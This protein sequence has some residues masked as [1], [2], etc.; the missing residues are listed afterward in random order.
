MTPPSP[1]SSRLTTTVHSRDAAGKMYVY[2]V[3]SRRAGGVSIGINL[4]PNHACNWRCIYCQVPGLTLGSGPPTD[5]PRLRDEL[6]QML[7]EILHG[8]FLE[9]RV[10]AEAR[11]L[12]DVA[13]SGD[14]EPTTSPSFEEAVQTVGEVLGEH[15]LVGA[16]DVVLITNGSQLQRPSVQAGVSALARLGGTVW[17]KLD[18]GNRDGFRAINSSPLDPNRHL[19][20]LTTCAALCQTFV[21]TCVFT[22]AGAPPQEAAVVSYLDALRSV[23]GTPG[24]RGVLLYNLARESQQPEA[25]ELGPVSEAW[26]QALARRIGPLGLE[27]RVAS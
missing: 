19:E 14:G 3:V 1:D 11:T 13:F 26:M 12:K 22:R 8:D 18:A 25:P 21:Q 24:L 20:R 5:I 17:F 16:I 27:V 2:P 9:R 15:G 6:R 4:N 10:P 7:G 23:A